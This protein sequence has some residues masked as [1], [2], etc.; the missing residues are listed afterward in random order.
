MVI[1]DEQVINSFYYNN[2]NHNTNGVK[3][4][5]YRATAIKV[6]QKLYWELTW[7][8]WFSGGVKNES[9]QV[10][11]NRRKASAGCQSRLEALCSE[12]DIGFISVTSESTDFRFSVFFSLLEKNTFVSWEKSCMVIIK[13]V[14]QFLF[15]RFFNFFIAAI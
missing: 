2:S 7:V 4:T 15:S 11:E 5:L 10:Q 14:F 12:K 1:P 6:A 3:K 9:Y 8:C 13:F